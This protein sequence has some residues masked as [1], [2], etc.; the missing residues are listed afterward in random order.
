MSARRGHLAAVPGEGERGPEEQVRERPRVL[1]AVGRCQQPGCGAPV[2]KP[3]STR[4]GLMVFEAEPVPLTE[5]LVEAGA[6]YFLWR[7]GNDQVL[8][9][10]AND[11]PREAYPDEKTA[12]T[13]HVC[14]S[15]LDSQ[16]A[17][18]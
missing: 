7:G 15:I 16:G 4:Y 8:I 3:V 17:D 9:V 18:A 6:A 14:T 1:A 5:A 2:R 10:Q 12:L 13:P 11:V